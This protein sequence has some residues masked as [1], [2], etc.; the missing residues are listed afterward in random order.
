MKKLT[1]IA[2]LVLALVLV[3]QLV[4]FACEP[5]P[6]EPPCGCDC[7]CKAD[8]SPG[9]WKNHTFWMAAYPD[10]DDMLAALKAKGW[11]EN[12]AER[13]VVTD[14]LNTAYPDANCH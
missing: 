9:Y 1:A 6:P 2:V 14:I 3:L 13:W 8:C 5:P 11:E 7:G 4:S 10:A 12:F